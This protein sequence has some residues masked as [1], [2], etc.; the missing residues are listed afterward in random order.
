MCTYVCVKCA[1]VHACVTTQDFTWQGVVVYF[2]L[3]ITFLPQ[4]S[5]LFDMLPIQPYCVESSVKFALSHE[6]LKLIS[7]PDTFIRDF[8]WMKAFIEIYYFIKFMYY[9]IY[10]RYK[11]QKLRLQYMNRQNNYFVYKIKKNSRYQ[12]SLIQYECMRKERNQLLC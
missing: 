5:A 7:L 6:V 10:K 9:R 3:N 12:I 8:L 2:P 11:T 4:T 1:C